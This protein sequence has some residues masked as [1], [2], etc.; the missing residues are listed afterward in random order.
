MKNISIEKPKSVIFDIINGY[1]INAFI[2]H[3]NNFY[4]YTNIVIGSQLTA[5][6]II[7]ELINDKYSQ[8]K[9]TAITLNYLLT[10]HQEILNPE[11]VKEYEQ[12]YKELQE[13]RVICKNEAKRLIEY[14]EIND[15]HP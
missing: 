5:D 7:S 1:T 12:E 13:Y 8:D 2:S 9:V 6:L 15:V 10:L 11:K 4:E 3:I 14:A